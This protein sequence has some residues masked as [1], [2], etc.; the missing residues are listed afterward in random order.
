MSRDSCVKPQVTARK[1]GKRHAAFKMEKRDRAMLE[2]LT[3]DAFRRQPKPVAIEFHRFLKFINPERHNFQIVASLPFSS[4]IAHMP[5]AKPP[6][7][8]QTPPAIGIL[9]SGGKIPSATRSNPRHGQTRTRNI[10]H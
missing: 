1:Q 5:V 9:L 3:N 10:V 4:V 7:S 2:L 8:R 6:A